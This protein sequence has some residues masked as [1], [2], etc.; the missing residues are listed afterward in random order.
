MADLDSPTPDTK[1]INNE[2]ADELNALIE[3]AVTETLNEVES[4][5]TEETVQPLGSK[6]A[7]R[8]WALLLQTYEVPVPYTAFILGQAVAYRTIRAATARVAKEEGDEC[9][10]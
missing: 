9:D 8:F 2:E 7:A 1:P 6:V 4:P 5:L 10:A 3:H